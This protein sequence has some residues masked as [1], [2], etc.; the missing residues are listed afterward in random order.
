MTFFF[1][2]NLLVL[3]KI[4]SKNIILK[5]LKNISFLKKEININIYNN[6]KKNFLFFTS[7]K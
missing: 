5:T 6:K 4:K 1:K 7:N 3:G 2:Y